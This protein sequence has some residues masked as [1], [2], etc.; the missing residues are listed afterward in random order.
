M[1]RGIKLHII[2]KGE[3]PIPIKYTGKMY[4]K[5]TNTSGHIEIETN[6]LDFIKE[7]KTKGFVQN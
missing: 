4:C 7:M 5:I 1:E 3:K 2:S 6:D